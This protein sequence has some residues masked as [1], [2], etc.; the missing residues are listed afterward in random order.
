[1]TNEGYLPL[2]IANSCHGKG[3]YWYIQNT[4]G[5]KWLISHNQMKMGLE[6]FMPNSLKGKI[7][8][9]VMPFIVLNKQIRKKTGIKLVRFD[10]T[11]VYKR[12]METVFQ[13]DGLEYS[14][15]LGSPGKNQKTTIQFIKEKKILGYCKIT[16]KPHIYDLFENERNILIFLEEK[17][18]Q[19]V[20]RCLYSGKF[21]SL[22]LFAQTTKRTIFSNF[23]YHDNLAWNFVK[24]LYLKTRRVVRFETSDY[25]TMLS[26]L[27]ILIKE[28]DYAGK[29]HLEEIIGRVLLKY[30]YKD[31]EFSFY[32]GDFTPWNS[33]EEEGRLFVFDFEYGKYLYPPFLDYFHYFTQSALNKHKSTEWIVTF[34]KKKVKDKIKYNMGTTDLYEMYLLDIIQQYMKY[35]IIGGE[36]NPNLEKKIALWINILKQI[37]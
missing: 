20:P 17:G 15:F 12:K 21:S 19:G 29:A 3:K 14:F 6:L 9:R 7:V 5:Q 31:L 4:V 32:H 34:F 16:D 11:E 37:R 1:M 30:Q 22:Y 33:F 28:Y 27:Q 18:V 24:T 2:E 10:I 13:T 25:H 23:N 36:A 35:D 26:E 8:K